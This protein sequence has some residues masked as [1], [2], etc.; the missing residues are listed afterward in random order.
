MKFATRYSITHPRLA[1]L[2]PALLKDSAKE[3]ITSATR[4]KCNGKH[5]NIC[6]LFARRCVII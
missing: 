5:A 3:H 2:S 6:F 4:R 1:Q